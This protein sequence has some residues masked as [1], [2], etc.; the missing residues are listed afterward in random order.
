MRTSSEGVS[1]ERV[2]PEGLANDTCLDP[3][4]ALR[5]GDRRFILGEPQAVVALLNAAVEEPEDL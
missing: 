2:S 3:D 1:L 4:S 5:E